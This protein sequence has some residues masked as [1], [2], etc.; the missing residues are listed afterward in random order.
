[1]WLNRKVIDD[2]RELTNDLKSAFIELLD[3]NKWLDSKTKSEAKSKIRSISVNIAE[4]DVSLN[5][6]ELKLF[7]KDV[8]LL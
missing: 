6:T 2:L 1:M 8:S 3:E 5:D 4:P 7:L